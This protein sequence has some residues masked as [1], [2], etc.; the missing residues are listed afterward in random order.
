MR[1]RVLLLLTSVA[2]ALVVASGTALAEE[3]ENGLIYYSDGGEIYSIDPAATNPQPTFVSLGHSFDLS[4]DRTTLVYGRSLFGPGEVGPFYLFP[5]GGVPDDPDDPYDSNDVTE[6]Q[7][8]NTR[9]TSNC[10]FNFCGHIKMA[11]PRFSPDGQTI[12]FTGQQV[13]ASDTDDKYHLY[14]VPTEGGEATRIPINQDKH[15]SYFDL[16]HDG[17]KVAIGGNDGVYTAPVGGGDTTRI[18]NDGCKGAHYPSF[19]PDDQTIVYTANIWSGDNCSGTHQG[20]VYTTPANNDGTKPGTPLLT[21]DATNANAGSKYYPTFSPDGTYVAFGD[22]SNNTYK[23][24]IAPATGASVTSIANCFSCHPLW[25]EKDPPPPFPETKIDSFTGDWPS[26]TTAT[27]EF[28]SSDTEATFQCKLDDGAYESC[29]SPRT[30]QDLSEGNHTFKVKAISSTGTELI[31]ASYDWLVDINPP[32]TSITNGPDEGSTIDTDSATFEFSSNESAWFECRLDGTSD[33]DWSYCTSPK[34]YT[35]LSTGSHTFEVKAIDDGGNEDSSPASRTWTVDK[36]DTTAPTTT[37]ALSPPPNAAGWNK[38]DTTLTLSATDDDSGVKEIAY[39]VNGGEPIT[40][41]QSSVQIPVTDEGETTISYHATD[42]AGNKE[43]PAKTITVKLD[44][45]APTVGSTV[46]GSNA[47]G[48]LRGTNLTATFDEKI[49]GKMD[50]ASVT[51]ATFKL[52]RCS[53]TTSTNCTALVDDTTYR[54]TVKLGTTDGITATLDPYGTSKKLLGSRTKY[55]AVVTTGAK[56][57]A[58]NALNQ[59]KEWYFTTGRT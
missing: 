54:T 32:D 4:P 52:Y 39:S 24:A 53:S 27:I 5:L 17:K 10:S 56:D 12:Y 30:Y 46:P 37:H 20:T 23:L 50:P 29:T 18:T 3:K 45:S 40:V 58:G 31:P 2:L 57:L 22:W 1:R 48:V 15:F 19:S 34:T 59:Q 9:D 7:I 35:G 49:S 14:S 55:K 25:V 6:I 42:N 13:L 51:T 8:T 43:S 33:N 16:S 47:T 36:P 11:N 44:K 41:Q 38:G 28:S 26:S 21:A